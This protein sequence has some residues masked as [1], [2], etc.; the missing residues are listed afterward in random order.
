MQPVTL[1]HH[2]GKAE[3]LRR[4]G[5]KRHKALYP[6][7]VFTEPAGFQML[8]VIGIII[9]T[10]KRRK[11]LKPLD[12]KP[13]PVHIGESERPFDRIHPPLTPPICYGSYEG[14]AHFHAVDEV[15]PAEAD[16]PGVPALIGLWI[17]DGGYTAH[18]RAVFIFGQETIVMAI[19]QRW[20]GRTEGLHLIRYER[21]HPIRIPFIQLFRK[22]NE[23]P[24]LAA[25]LHSFNCY[26]HHDS[27]YQTKITIY[28][29]ST[30]AAAVAAAGKASAAS[31]GR[32]SAKTAGRASGP[33]RIFTL[34][35]PGGIF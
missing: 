3:E 28:F 13:F 32:T 1:F 29:V 31:N 6:V 27:V 16:G 22:K 12:Q 7:R 24:Q 5:R 15:Y 26:L 10:R 20:I 23:T 33:L 17:Y 2:L 30:A 8:A 25:V 4:L 14:A 11:V 21:G 9:D 35:H 34:R 18:D 19:L